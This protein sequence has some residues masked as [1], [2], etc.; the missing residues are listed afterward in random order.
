M[1]FFHLFI[2]EDPLMHVL[3]FLMQL[4]FAQQIQS[5]QMTKNEKL[6]KQMKIVLTRAGQRFQTASNTIVVTVPRFP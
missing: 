6:Q 5:V 4:L 2:H 1:I 3:Y